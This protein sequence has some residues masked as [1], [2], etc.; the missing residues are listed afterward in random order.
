M[1]AAQTDMHNQTRGARSFD[2]D[3]IILA[4]KKATPPRMLCRGKR[5]GLLQRA[6]HQSIKKGNNIESCLCVRVVLV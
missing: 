2:Y 6:W 1:R 3:F 4:S 5:P